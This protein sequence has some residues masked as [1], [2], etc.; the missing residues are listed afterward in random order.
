MNGKQTYEESRHRQEAR[1]NR[2]RADGQNGKASRSQE[3][4]GVP[5]GQVRAGEQ[6]ALRAEVEGARLHH[7]ARPEVVL[8]PAR[9]AVR[10]AVSGRAKVDP[11]WLP[12]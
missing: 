12:E 4:T 9:T 3:E 2:R 7:R 11:R 6:D 5:R 8:G 10:R 1:R